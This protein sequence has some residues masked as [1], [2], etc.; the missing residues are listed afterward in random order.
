M[1]LGRNV[2]VH[3]DP[4][5]GGEGETLARGRCLGIEMDLSLRIE[6]SAEP[7]ASGRLILED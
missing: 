5:E 2:S 7:V 6:G 4:P 1:I 3:S